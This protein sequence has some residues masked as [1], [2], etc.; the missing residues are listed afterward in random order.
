MDYEFRIKLA[1]KELAHL[2]EMHDL[3]RNRMDANEQGFE[4]LR[5]IV[6]RTAANLDVLTVQVSRLEAK[7]DTLVDALLRGRNGE[8][9]KQ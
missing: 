2:R 4:S 8:G 6:E 3:H 5:A 9:G 7:I 1:E